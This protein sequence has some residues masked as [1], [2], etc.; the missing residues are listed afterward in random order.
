M[1]LMET[2]EDAFGGE[3]N[4][5]ASRGHAS[6][7]IAAL[8]RQQIVDCM[9]DPLVLTCQRKLGR[10]EHRRAREGYSILSVHDL[11]QKAKEYC[12]EGESNSHLRITQAVL[13]QI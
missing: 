9:T 11:E 5:A 12:L 3:F 4:S 8:D 6:R 10:I 2:Q 13:G 7:S 1:L